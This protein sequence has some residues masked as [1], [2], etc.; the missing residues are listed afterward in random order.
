MIE[1]QLQ[2]SGITWNFINKMDRSWEIRRDKV[3]QLVFTLTED[4]FISDSDIQLKNKDK[5]Q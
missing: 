2:G 1:L 4:E 3:L 5:F